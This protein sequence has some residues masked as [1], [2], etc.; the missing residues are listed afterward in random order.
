VGNSIVG[1]FPI[2]DKFFLAFSVVNEWAMIFKIKLF[3]FVDL[4]SEMSTKY[5][6]SWLK[7]L[8]KKLLIQDPRWT[9]SEAP[10]IKFDF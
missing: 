8:Q 9:F 6:R 1:L 2:K 10:N 3:V 4:M 7:H 5:V